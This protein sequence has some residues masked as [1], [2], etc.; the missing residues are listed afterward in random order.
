MCRW[1]LL[2]NPNSRSLRSR[3]RNGDCVRAFVAVTDWGLLTLGV[4][5]H[6]VGLA[7]RAP[8][9]PL[10]GCCGC[11]IPS[12][13]PNAQCPNG[14]EVSRNKRIGRPVVRSYLGL[15]HTRALG[16]ARCFFS[17][18]WIGHFLRASLF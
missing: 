5:V 11:C 8:P 12:L 14:T 9:P 4:L 6:Q 16:Y 10:C 13:L 7:R 17:R 2:A 1:G 18:V 15:F 3:A